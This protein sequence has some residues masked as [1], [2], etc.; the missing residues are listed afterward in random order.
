MTYQ[1]FLTLKQELCR[2]SL[3]KD[4]LNKN[5]VLVRL[6]EFRRQ[7]PRKYKEFTERMKQTGRK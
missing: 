5:S 6:A 4:T 1:E 2:A 7:E 3:F